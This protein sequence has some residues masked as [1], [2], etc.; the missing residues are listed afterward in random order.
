[1][2]D[3]DVAPAQLGHYIFNNPA[4]L[5]L[6]LTHRSAGALH[7]QRLEFLGD[8]ILNLLIA[9]LVFQQWPHANE[10]MLSRARSALV[11]EQALADIARTL[12]LGSRLILGNG[13]IKN[14]GQY[15]DSILADTLEAVVAAIYMDAGLEICRKQVLPWFESAF[16]TLSAGKPQK[17]PKTQLQEWM[18]AR[19]KPLPNYIVVAVTGDNEQNRQFQVRCQLINPLLETE[20]QGRSRKQAEQQA[21]FSA[22]QQLDHYH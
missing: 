10:G 20:G 1:V 2:P 5:S 8:S 15:R 13:E 18:Q 21:A 16:H 9:E 12:D 4:L 6:A 17:D 19:K 11:C 7:N 22:L 14:G 3:S